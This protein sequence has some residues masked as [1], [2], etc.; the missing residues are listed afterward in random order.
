[1][2]VV[3]HRAQLA[4]WLTLSDSGKYCDGA[5]G[6]LLSCGQSSGEQDFGITAS[7]SLRFYTAP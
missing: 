6:R 3:P 2:R 5:C 7:L 1:M 4:T